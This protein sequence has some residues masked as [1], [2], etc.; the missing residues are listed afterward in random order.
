M[1]RSP[2]EIMIDRATGRD[3]TVIMK[4]RPTVLLECGVCDRVTSAVLGPDEP[5]G[6][7]RIQLPCPNCNIGQLAK[8]FGKDGKLIED[9]NHEG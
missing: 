6:T 8:Y 2:L 9:K 7:V 3:S 4:P 1:A 5:K